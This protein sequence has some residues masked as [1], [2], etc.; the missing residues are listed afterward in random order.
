M[1]INGARKYLNEGNSE[2]D[3]NYNKTI[4]RNILKNKINKISNIVKKLKNNG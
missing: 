2:L 1:T 3:E 4:K